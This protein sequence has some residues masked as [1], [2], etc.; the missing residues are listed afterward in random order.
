MQTISFS[1]NIN[2]IN[3][4][5]QWWTDLVL[6]EKSKLLQVDAGIVVQQLQSSKNKKNDTCHC[7]ICK[8]NVAPTNK[9]IAS[10]LKKKLIS[11]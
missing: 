4:L 9:M 2:E 1:K 6:S 5:K 3:K 8:G 7:D 11:F 10:K